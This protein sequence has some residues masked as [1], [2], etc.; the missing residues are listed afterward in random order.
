MIDTLLAL[1]VF[2]SFAASA[3]FLLTRLWFITLPAAAVALY[4]WHASSL[5]TN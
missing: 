1:L 5:P 3:Y 2:F 4:L